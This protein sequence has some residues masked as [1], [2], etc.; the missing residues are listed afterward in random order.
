MV[1][2][3]S[4]A[5]MDTVYNTSSVHYSK[6]GVWLPTGSTSAAPIHCALH[7]LEITLWSTPLPSMYTGSPQDVL[8]FTACMEC[9]C[10]TTASWS[11]PRAPS[12]VLMHCSLTT[13]G[14]A[15]SNPKHTLH[16]ARWSL[17]KGESATEIVLT[18]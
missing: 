3:Q 4:L 11:S 17:P 16:Y 7:M 8:P 2:L 1:G 13:V 10:V 6:Q 5:Y 12:A 14:D 18:E 15:C 9:D